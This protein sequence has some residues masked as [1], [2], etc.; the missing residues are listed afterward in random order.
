MI[1]ELKE[2]Q[3]EL[4]EDTKNGMKSLNSFIE[5]YN[6]KIIELKENLRKAKVSYEKYEDTQTQGLI[7]ALEGAL[8]KLQEMS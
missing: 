5:D 2:I 6:N 8:K 4:W 3:K 7:F 1:N